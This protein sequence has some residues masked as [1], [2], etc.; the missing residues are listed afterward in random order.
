MIKCEIYNFKD[1]HDLRT[2]QATWK[3]Y[4][5]K[6]LSLVINDKEFSSKASRNFI[7]VYAITL[8]YKAD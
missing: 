1:C 6:V 7:G 2:K 4:T 8:T 5:E 3:R